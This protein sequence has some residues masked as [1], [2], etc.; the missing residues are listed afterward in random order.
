[1]HVVLKKSKFTLITIFKGNLPL[2]QSS[3]SECVGVGGPSTAG[4]TWFV[5][6]TK[7]WLWLLFS[8]VIPCTCLVEIIGLDS[9]VSEVKDKCE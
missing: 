7:D 2:E 8:A 9:L 4:P 5:S 6:I 3:V 1:M